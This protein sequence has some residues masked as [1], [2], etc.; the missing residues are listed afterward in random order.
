M[1]VFLFKFSF[2]YA[3]TGISK[4]VSE[5]YDR[6][7]CSLWD[8]GYLCFERSRI[9]C[10][11]KFVLF[12][13]HSGSVLDPTTCSR[14]SLGE[15]RKLVHEIAQCSK[16]AQE[17]LRSF[18]R[19]ELLEIICSEMGKERKYTGYSKFQM[20]E[21]LLK[22]VSQSS[23][24][25]SM[26]AFCPAKIQVQ[27]KRQRNIEAPLQSLNY[28]DA[29]TNKEEHAKF[30]VCENV[31]CKANLSFEDTF[32]KRC[33]CCICHCYDDNKDPSLWL[34]CG[35]DSGGENNSCGM[36][37]HLECAL[38]Q[39]RRILKKDRCSTMESCFKCVYCGRV[40]DI[41]R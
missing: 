25:E 5:I 32:C 9:F 8:F 10:F 4:F 22:L 35:S 26:S 24:T 28:L 19:K 20:I 21:H 33:S 36:S 17:V 6:T 16:D 41:M 40:Y 39:K 18:T 30:R 12:F 3:K 37:C 38:K 15:K 23:N 14:L 2:T 11:N 29:V 13:P 7:S 27:N 1:D 34:T 31:V